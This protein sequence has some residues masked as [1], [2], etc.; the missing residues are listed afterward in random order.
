M[1]GLPAQCGLVST[2]IFRGR[3]RVSAAVATGEIEKKKMRERKNQQRALGEG[4]GLKKWM[5]AAGGF[6]GCVINICEINWLCGTDGRGNRT[7]PIYARAHWEPWWNWQQHP[8]LVAS[9]TG[10][11]GSTADSAL[12]FQTSICCCCCCVCCCHP[13]QRQTAANNAI[14]FCLPPLIN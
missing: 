8:S 9:V 14:F 2:A 11:E 13:S 5:T 1:V 7:C 3:H 4:G 6:C 10:V 12:I